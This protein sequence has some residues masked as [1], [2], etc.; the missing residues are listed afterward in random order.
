[1]AKYNA[2]SFIKSRS[3]IDRTFL[4]INTLPKIPS[5]IYDEEY[6]ISQEFHQRPDLLAYK[7]YNSSRLWWVFAMRNL[8]ALKDPI[9]DFK[10]GT[11]IKLP[12]PDVIKNSFM[13]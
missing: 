4:D 11:P 9:R 10:A 8:D 6:V 7:L 1:M 5:S 12:S 3:L 13:S 2:Q